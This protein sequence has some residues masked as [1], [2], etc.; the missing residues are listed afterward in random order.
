MAE[1]IFDTDLRIGGPAGPLIISG[2]GTPEGV[3][4][5]PVGSQFHRTD[6]GA[7]TTIYRKETGTGNTG[8][9]AT[10]AGGG[11]GDVVGPAAATDN[12][13]PRFDAATG[14]LLQASAV[15]LDD[16][17]V[18]TLPAVATPA[19]PATGFVKLFTK[20]FGA[21][22]WPSFMLPG[23]LRQMALQPLIGVG[24]YV[25]FV[26]AVGTTVTNLGMSVA[27]TGTATAI[28]VT[29][30]SRLGRLKRVAYRVTVS[31]TAVAGWRNN[32]AQW[33]VGGPNAGEGGF[34]GVM[35]GGPDT[36]STNASHR[37]F[38]GLHGT[39]APTDVNPST[40]FDLVG[41]GYDT[42][43]TQVQFL[44][45]DASGVATKIALGASFP[46]PNVDSSSAY[47]LRLYS[48]P[49]TTQRVDYEVENLV[50]GAIA[51]GTVTTNLPGTGVLI[52][53]KIYASVG[54]VSSVIG[55]MIGNVV[56][57]TED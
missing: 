48:P 26:V 57:Q 23:A 53:Q 7:G 5:A 16:T 30:G 2:A 33:S 9:V 8:W 37:F 39:T 54:G 27:A 46:K 11:S 17:G 20:L 56:F 31:A 21:I 41:I 1:K 45:N 13:L 40:L 25:L 38:M 32:A 55:A 6:G 42:A 36:G 3:V 14:K 12:A 15:T 24:N 44:H 10:A 4:T 28:N 35:T 29:S 52:S 34:H 47:R 22:S 43:D 51:S 18:F 49:G 19:V 50:N